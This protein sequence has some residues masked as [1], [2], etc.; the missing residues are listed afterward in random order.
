MKKNKP[1]TKRIFLVFLISCMTLAALLVQARITSARSAPEAPSASAQTFTSQFNS[2][3]LSQ[4]TVSSYHL[5][6]VADTDRFGLT[7]I[8]KGVSINDKGMIAF[9]GWLSTGGNGIFVV[10]G[11]KPGSITS[12]HSGRRY[13]D[14]VMLN[15]NMVVA[16]DRPAAGV[17]TFVRVWNAEKDNDYKV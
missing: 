3:G 6:I 15:S 8:G 7:S 12:Q 17:A 10:G 5:Q 9:T 11:G 16:S 1:I 4:P 2:Q 13:I 14:A